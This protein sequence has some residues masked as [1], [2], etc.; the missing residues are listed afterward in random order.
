M[1]RLRPKHTDVKEIDG[2]KFIYYDPDFRGKTKFVARP[3]DA[4][5]ITVTPKR[6]LTGVIETQSAVPDSF[7]RLDESSSVL[8]SSPPFS[9]SL[10]G[11]ALVLALPPIGWLIGLIVW[12]RIFPTA[13]QRQARQRSRSAQRA[14]ARLHTGEPPWVV[15]GDYLRGRFEFTVSDPTPTD[16]AGFLKRRGFAKE[17]S[18]SAAAFFAQS[19]AVRY[20]DARA[21][22]QKMRD[23]GARLIQALEADPCAR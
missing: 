16:V 8:A 10:T 4:M 19:D 6:D 23:D 17:C 11:I 15:V 21:D 12:R 18:R 3:I 2:L 1:Y 14:L 13:A 20:T 9:I 22:S 5:P 7:Y